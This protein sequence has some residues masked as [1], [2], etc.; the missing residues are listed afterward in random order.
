MR[1][2]SF[3]LRLRPSFDLVESGILTVMSIALGLSWY[4]IYN[5]VKAIIIIGGK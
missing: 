2:E 3:K 5:I 1:H 4:A